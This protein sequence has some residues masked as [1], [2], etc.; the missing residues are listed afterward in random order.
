[1]KVTRRKARLF[2]PAVL[3]MWLWIFPALHGFAAGAPLNY[4]QTETIDSKAFSSER[5]YFVHLPEAYEKN[6]DKSYPVLYVLHGQWDLIS[7]VAIAEAISN[8][9]PELIIIGV[10]SRGPELRPAVNS[11]G[12]ENPAGKQFRSFLLDEL[13]PHSRQTYRIADFS[14]LSGHSNSGRFVLNT[15]LD[16]PRLFDAYFAFSPSLD[17]EVINKRVMQNPSALTDS[18]ARLFMTLA[19]EGE[20]MQVPY[21]QLVSQFSPSEP[22]STEFFHEEFPDQTHAASKIA[23]MLFSLNTL[24]D[25]WQP[26]DEVQAEGLVGLKRHYSGLSEKYQFEVEIPLHF[27]LRVIYFYSASPDEEHNAKAAELV[28]FALNRDPGSVDDFKELIEA[29]NQQAEEAGAQRLTAFVCAGQPQN[30]LCE[31]L[32]K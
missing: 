16:D 8:S 6:S 1:M 9:I 3:I 25:G 27:I 32:S 17:D 18:H 22:G 10:D 29:L 13:L 20:H 21:N 23:S 11:D 24:F 19:N 5:E 28:E 26:A 2:W 15:F 7:T 30:T 14:V 31:N 4:G 12:T